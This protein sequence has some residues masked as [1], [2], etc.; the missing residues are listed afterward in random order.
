[1]HTEINPKTGLPAIVA[2]RETFDGQLV[3]FTFCEAFPI[4]EDDF[5]RHGP[6]HP[7]CN[8]VLAGNVW[9]IPDTNTMWR[10]ADE[11][12]LMT[13]DELRDALKTWGVPC[14]A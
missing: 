8:L 6:C 13:A 10:C 3:V 7:T 14:V 1:M 2:F 12:P 4:D 11:A 9:Q 5:H